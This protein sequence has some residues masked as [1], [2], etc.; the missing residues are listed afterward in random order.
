MTI[1]I[2]ALQKEKELCPEHVPGIYYGSHEMSLVI[3]E[4]LSSHK[5]LRGE[6]MRGKVFRNF[7]EHITTFMAEVLFKTSDLYLDHQTK[8]EMV[9]KYINYDLCKIT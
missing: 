9:S 7:A 3:M 6:I 4:N 5:V 8:K 2:M 1:E